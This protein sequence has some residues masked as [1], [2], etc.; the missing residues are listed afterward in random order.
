MLR[1]LR[2]FLLQG[3]IHRTI[4]KKKTLTLAL[5]THTR[6]IDARAVSMATAID[7]AVVTFPSEITHA[8]VFSATLS[9]VTTWRPASSE[10]KDRKRVSGEG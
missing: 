5:V 7:G 10:S 8:L 4:P 6:L 3:A 2:H 1:S 9:V